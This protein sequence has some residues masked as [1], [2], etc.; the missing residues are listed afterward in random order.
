[1]LVYIILAILMFGVL[2][3]VHEWG[4]FIAAKRLGVR[5]NEFAIG[6]GPALWSKQ[7]GETLYSLRA[8]PIGGFCAMEGEDEDTA[9]PDS[10][11]KK[12]LWRKLVILCAGSFMN[13]VAGLL[14]LLLLLSQSTGFAV[15]VIQSFAEGFPGQSEEGLL[16]GDRIL[17]VDGRKVHIY[18]DV[19]LYFNLSNGETMNLLIQR[20][21][22]VMERTDFPLKPREYMTNGQSV[23]RYGI[24]FQSVVATPGRVLS[25]TWGTAGY[26]ARSVWLGLQMLA[27]GD[28]GM[29]DLAG[30]VGI[31]SMIGETSAQAGAQSLM[32]GV[33]NLCYIIALVAVNLAIMNMLPIPALDGGRVF[34]LLVGKGYHLLTR[35][36]LNSK[37]EAY[38]H[39]AGFVLLIGLMVIVTFQDVIKLV[40]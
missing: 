39:A 36:E 30:P 17:A 13:F 6:M 11:A 8:F 14:L 37:Y 4:H 38:I 18:S 24:N 2:I 12:S 31:V 20:D 27:K 25:E 9:S 5:V 16:P 35:R 3:A 23:L 15:P 7:K 26:F 10:F 34:L 29:K 33:M 28:A 1:M 40:R 32:A 19:T 21:G 22:Q